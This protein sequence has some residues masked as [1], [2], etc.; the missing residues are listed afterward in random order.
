M[1]EAEAAAVEKHGAAEASAIREKL[2][3]EAQGFA[4]KAASMKALDDSGRGHEEFRLHLENERA[5]ALESL[6]VKK[7]IVAAQAQ[8]HGR[9]HVARRRSTSSAATASSSTASSAPSRSVNRSTARSSRAT[10][11]ARWSRTSLS[12]DGNGS[13]GAVLAAALEKLAP[14]DGKGSGKRP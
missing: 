6:K 11:C 13:G 3:A 10:R 4:Q 14:K 1:R 7:D 9:G 2:T 12:G 8:R 5:I